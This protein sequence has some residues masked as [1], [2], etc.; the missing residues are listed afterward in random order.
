[1]TAEQGQRLL[2]AVLDSWDRS[3]QALI[4]LLRLVPEGGLDARVVESSPTVCQ[5]F[6]HLHHERMISVFEN[7]P[8]YAGPV[9]A[10]EWATERDV[11]RIAAM[12]DDSRT[13][14]RNSVQGRLQ[15]GRAFDRDFAHPIQLLQFLIFHDNY[16]HGQIKLALKAGGCPLPDDAAGPLIWDVWRAR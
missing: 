4:N 6:A 13:R 7:A 5:M 10:E 9:P 1:M 16:H 14:V 12:L 15:S 2:D 8:E 3:N 11:Q